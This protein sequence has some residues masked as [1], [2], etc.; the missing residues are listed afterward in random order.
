L[1]AEYKHRRHKSDFDD[2]IDS[3]P[4]GYSAFIRSRNSETDAVETRLVFRPATWMKTSL[5][6]QFAATD[7]RTTTDPTSIAFP[8]PTL[9]LPAASV[10]AGKHDSSTYSANV[11]LIPWR[12]LSVSTTVSFQESR[13]VTYDNQSPSVVPYDGNVLS[14]LTSATFALNND[15]DW[16]ATYSFS[17]ARYGQ[18]NFASGLPL[19]IDYDHHGVQ[20]GL[21]H[22]FN[23]NVTANVQYGFFKYDEPTSGGFADYSAHVIFGALAIRLP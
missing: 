22:R 9:N 4:T 16:T 7:Y 12:R 3:S 19:G 1:N 23:S 5:S 13:I 2:D 14:V 21:S 20:A 18:G 17:R 8:P 11:T 15:T 10:H 6:Y